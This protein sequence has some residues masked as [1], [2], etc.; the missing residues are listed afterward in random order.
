MAKKEYSVTEINNYIKNLIGSDYVLSRV[1]VKGEVSNSKYHSAGHIYFSL[2]D[3]KSS[4]SCIMFRGKAVRGLGFRL[5]DG[6]EVVISGSFGLYEASGSIQIYVDSI[7]LSENKE[8]KLFAEFNRLK[9]KLSEEGL[10][11]FE[12]KK[13]I[14]KFPKS[15]GIVT[16]RTGAAIHDIISVSKRR[17]PYTQ[18]ILYPAKVQGDG[19]AETIIKGIETLD[20]MGLDTI[21]IG[22]GGGSIEDLWA[23]NDERLARTIY[24]AKTPIISGTG[25]DIDNTIADYVSDLRAPTPSA[26]AELAIPDVMT[27][28][29]KAESYRSS[30]EN[31]INTLI[32]EYYLRLRNQ[33]LRLESLSPERSIYDKEQ[34]L[35]DL[36]DRLKTGMADILT[37]YRHRL[38]L[39]TV[40]LNGLSP[41]AKLVN[42]FGYV[43]DK[44][45]NPVRSVSDVNAGN[46]LSVILHDGRIEVSVN[47]ISK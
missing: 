36:T 38:E 29:R 11:D 19:A 41:T 15:V 35:A 4:V 16:A 34:N 23:F 46:E 6:Q 26:A 42:G 22:R 32:T 25:H 45:D 30:L 27:H 28:I 1:L 17:N 9:E 31:R 37:R 47:G 3:E 40:R 14:P 24:A 8:G 33:K 20:K 21:I 12:H 7:V 5:E 44:D 2:K 43:T 10:F 13:A 18:L 39:D